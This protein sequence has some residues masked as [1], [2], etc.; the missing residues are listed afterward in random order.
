MTAVHVHMCTS[1]LICHVT[2]VRF[3]PERLGPHR[4]HRALPSLAARPNGAMAD[5]SE[6]F[7][8]RWA[9]RLPD[10]VR[11]LVSEAS[12]VPTS[13]SP[14]PGVTYQS[15]EQHV[16]AT[17]SQ[18]SSSPGM[19]RDAWANEQQ[20]V[21]VELENRIRDLEE[22]LEAARASPQKVL[23]P[24]DGPIPFTPTKGGVDASSA[25]NDW[26][27]AKLV[28]NDVE[29]EQI[30]A[31]MS[32]HC[33]RVDDALGG[34]IV[35]VVTE[36]RTED[37][38]EP[39]RRLGVD[40]LEREIGRPLSKKLLEQLEEMIDPE[41]PAPREL[42]L[43]GQMSFIMESVKKKREAELSSPSPQVGTESPATSGMTTPRSQYEQGDLQIGHSTASWLQS[44]KISDIVEQALLEPLKD[45]VKKE[46]DDS[47]VDDK[48]LDELLEMEYLDSLAGKDNNVSSAAPHPKP[49]AGAARSMLTARLSFAHIAVDRDDA[50]PFG[51][52]SEARREDLHGDE[53]VQGP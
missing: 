18:R 32:E 7:L 44:I 19:P 28:D 16:A 53:E 11:T 39:I 48:E 38:R 27:R 10:R 4:S 36:G 13:P 42:Q 14:K 9:G 26:L 29:P 52:A 1:R 40:L 5:A 21:V 47:L 6:R 45:F 31:W 12:G 3:I 23:P 30:T 22:Q 43:R 15:S 17:A 20:K 34:A 33:E 8:N 41:K 37:R 24:S 46:N 51:A 49:E 50:R 35:N 2:R 25:F